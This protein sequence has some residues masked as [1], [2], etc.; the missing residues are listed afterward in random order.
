MSTQYFFGPNA[1]HLPHSNQ[2]LTF[3]NVKRN[4]GASPLTRRRGGLA[5]VRSI[6]ALRAAQAMNRTTMTAP[7][8]RQPARL[9][10]AMSA[11][12][13]PVSVLF[14]EDDIALRGTMQRSPQACGYSVATATTPEAALTL[15]Q[16]ELPAGIVL[17]VDVPDGSGPQLGGESPG[18]LV[19][20]PHVEQA[21]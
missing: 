1:L 11:A 20:G 8:R 15:L 18:A 6:R 16:R 19:P 4:A 3:G 12:P 17:D 7:D 13:K 10:P 9:P 5:L 21:G 14:V 2:A